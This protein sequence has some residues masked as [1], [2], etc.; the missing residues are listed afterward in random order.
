MADKLQKRFQSVV[1]PY[2]FGLAGVIICLVVDPRQRPGLIYFAMFLVA[3]GLFP[4]IPGIVCWISNNVAGQWKRNISMGIEFTLGNLVG[5]VVGS[6]IFLSSESPKFR[7]AYLVLASF[8]ATGIFTSC[9]QLILLVVANRKDSRLI[10]AT[11]MGD[12]E[13]LDSELKDEGD[14]SPFF[15]Y[16]L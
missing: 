15:K 2:F 11:P 13:S 16:T 5:G 9:V 8:F 6:N 1:I 12:R 4:T 3:S 14:S 7:T 10:E